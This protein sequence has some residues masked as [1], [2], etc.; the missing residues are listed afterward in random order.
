MFKKIRQPELFQGHHRKNRYFEGW[1]FKSV[2]KDERLSLALIPGISL[3]RQDPHAF[4]QVFIARHSDDDV[5]LKTHYVRYDVDDFSYSRDVFRVQIGTSIFSGDH[6]DIE[7]QHDNLDIRGR[8]DIKDR[9]PIEKSLLA[10]NIMGIFGYVGFMECYHGV[11]SMSHRLE[12]SLMINHQ[13]VVFDDGKGYL[14]KDW[15][16]SFPRAYVWMQ[17]NHF[18]QPDT[19]F[20]CSYADIP[21]LGLFFKGLLA[22]LVIAGKEYRFATYNGARVLKEEIEKGKAV[23]LIKRGRLRLLIE[24]VTQKEIELA[25]PRMGVMNETIKEGLSGKVTLTLWRGREQI[26]HDTGTSAGI[27]IMK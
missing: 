19:S 6:I 26:Y 18:K 13:P 11:I 7:I 27:E 21:F 15:G 17:S 23:Y 24:A 8:L 12:G 4:I 3:N 14:E 1:Y 5:E 9:T 2:T 20:M 25:S 16:R 22:N 10:P